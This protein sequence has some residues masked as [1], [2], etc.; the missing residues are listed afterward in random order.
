MLCENTVCVIHCSRLFFRSVRWLSRLNMAAVGH[1][2]RERIRQE[3][4]ELY[5][6][7]H[8]NG[9]IDGGS[10]CP[11]V[12]FL[13]I[14]GVRVNM[15]RKPP[16]APNRTVPHLHMIPTHGLHQWVTHTQP[17]YTLICCAWRQQLSSVRFPSLSYCK[18]D[19]R[20]W[21]GTIWC[22]WC[23]TFPSYCFAPHYMICVF[24][25]TAF[26]MLFS[27]K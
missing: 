8:Y 2:E 4:G 19:S 18:L 5:E 10:D 9:C 21:C 17:Y 11:C 20:E 26:T 16:P 1:A 3:Q 12:G 13:K 15:R 7:R 6:I 22:N 14:T 25:T 24:K 27:V 23:Y